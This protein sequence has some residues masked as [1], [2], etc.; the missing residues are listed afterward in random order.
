[1]DRWSVGLCMPVLNERLNIET[2]LGEIV[3]EL[4]QHDFT[5]CVVDDGSTDGTA[6]FVR[7]LVGRDQRIVLIERQR[8]GTRCARGGATRAGL[9]W[10][11]ENTD[12][13]VFVDIDA[14]GAQHPSELRGGICQ[15]L[16]HRF[17][18]AIASKYV[19]G[20]RVVGRPLVRRLVSHLYSAAMRALVDSSIRDYSNSYR[21]YGRPAAE[22]LLEFE[23]RYEGPI[24][25]LEM[26]LHWIARDF[27]IVE[28][29]TQY[30]ERT[31]GTSKV[32]PMD[33]FAGLWGALRLAAGFRIAKWRWE[34]SGS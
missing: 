25:L 22:S 14:D 23:P 10:L 34:G 9:K 8:R 1:M 33:M 27:R 2:I 12:H 31:E 13:A 17:D 20:S 16:E 24:Y 3:S 26:M 11:L 5:I 21:F 18:V 15:V 7:D 30:Q 19:N 29:P 4:S 32:I 6:E 28:V